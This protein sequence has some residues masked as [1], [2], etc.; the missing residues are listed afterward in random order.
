MP[1]ADDF[2]VGPREGNNVHALGVREEDGEPG[3]GTDVKQLRQEDP[4]S[5][6]PDVRKVI[7]LDLI[8]IMMIS[9]TSTSGSIYL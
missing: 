1:E 4:R 2:R 6:Q 5:L 8:S 7:V 3:R 9:S